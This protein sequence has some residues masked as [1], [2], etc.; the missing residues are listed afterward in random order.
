MNYYIAHSTATAFVQE[1]GAHPA[2]SASIIGAASFGALVA[3]LFQLRGMSLEIG[4]SGRCG[5]TI[6]FFRRSFLIYGSL[7]IIG[8]V[9]H[10][11]AVSKGSIP[12]AVFG[13][14]LIGFGSAE[15]LHRQLLSSCLPAPHVVFE[16]AN[17]VHSHVFGVFCG[18]I[19][20]GFL[21]LF[22]VHVKKTTIS[23]LHS[24]SYFMAGCWLLHWVNVFRSF[25]EST[26]AEL[27]DANTDAGEQ[28]DSVNTNNFM[29]TTKCKVN[30][31]SNATA[32]SCHCNLHGC[33]FIRSSW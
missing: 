3:A 2:H 17:L 27:N 10:A 6:G 11:I 1:V 12:L 23:S 19:T 24:G 21:A 28:T 26:Q 13:R 29:L 25:Q 14:F 20:G 8:N 18:L 4:V 33:K 7:P 32:G 22:D 16:S 15:I 9:L 5:L 31:T 30:C